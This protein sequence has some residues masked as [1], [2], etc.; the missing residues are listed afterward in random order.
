MLII[1]SITSINI[2][3]QVLGVGFTDEFAFGLTVSF[4]VG[5]DCQILS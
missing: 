3:V 1:S 4:E 5:L 2:L